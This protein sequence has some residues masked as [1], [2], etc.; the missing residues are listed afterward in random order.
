MSADEQTGSSDSSASDPDGDGGPEAGPKLYVISG[1]SGSGKSTITARLAEGKKAV[2]SVSYTTR[3]RHQSEREGIN[4]RFV[5]RPRFDQLRADGRLLECAQVHGNWY[6][7]SRSDI[8]G[9]LR[10]NQN[11]MLEID[12]NGAEQVRQCGLP[13]VSIFIL[14]PSPED[15][16]GRLS[17]RQR[18][19][20][21][22]ISLRIANARKEVMAMG[23]FDFLVVNR[24]LDA[25]VR[26]VADIIDGRGE[27]SALDRQRQH[28]EKWQQWA[29]K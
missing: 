24:D 14:P 19:N 3:A 23:D 22:Q 17:E 13:Q 20:G 28:M 10:Q 27:K 1:P 26:D 21:E 5:S 25:A 15:L 7:T 2:F 6:G 11:V 12:I 4:Y 16:T 8:E 9:F 18:E 29:R